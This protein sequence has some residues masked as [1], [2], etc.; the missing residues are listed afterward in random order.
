MV[1]LASKSLVPLTITDFTYAAEH[2]TVMYHV[3]SLL[4]CLGCYCMVR[5]CHNHLINAG[6]EIGTLKMVMNIHSQHN[7]Y[8]LAY[9]ANV[10]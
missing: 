9:I 2:T 8:C 5:Y 3:L 4:V 6:K 7:G 1:E 10:S